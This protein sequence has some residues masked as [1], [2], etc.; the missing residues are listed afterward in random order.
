MNSAHRSTYIT[1]Y[2]DLIQEGEW[3]AE[4]LQKFL[5]RIKGGSNRLNRLVEDFLLLVR[6]ETD[7]ARQAYLMDKGPF[8][9]W[10][11]LMA[12]VFDRQHEAAAHELVE[13][14]ATVEPDLPLVEAHEG[15]LENAVMRL[16]DNG[17]KFAKHNGGHVWVEGVRRRRA[18]LLLDQGRRRGDSGRRRPRAC[19]IASI[20]STG[21]ASNSRAPASAWRSLRA[22]P[23]CIDGEVTCT[24]TEGVGTEF[25][26]APADDVACHAC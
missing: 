2:V 26:S 21:S 7:D 24:S 3:S 18:S 8:S 16:V 4:D 25:I 10:A 1:G 13:L 11:G 12:R 19:S 20:R 17:I 22:L 5:G 14:S 6:F 23:I 9:N 15:Y